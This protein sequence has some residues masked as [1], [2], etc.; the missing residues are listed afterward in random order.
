LWLIKDAVQW[1][2]EKLSC[3][4]QLVKAIAGAVQ[5]LV[6]GNAAALAK[7]VTDVLGQALPLVLSLIVKLAK[8]IWEGQ[9]GTSSMA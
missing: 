5:P 1:V 7:I 9:S 4:W 2:V 8:T 3:L 6:E